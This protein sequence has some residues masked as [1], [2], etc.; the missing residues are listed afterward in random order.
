MTNMAE[1]VNDELEEILA[2]EPD[3]DL[4]D[5]ED[6]AVETDETESESESDEAEAESDDDESVVVSIDGE[7][8]SSEDEEAERAPDWVRDL[9]KQHR[10]EKRRNRELQEQLEALSGA[11]KP[12]EL[13]KKPT[14]EAADFDTDRFE[15]ELEAWYEQK[16]ER[17][18]VET[19]KK[20]KQE[21]AEKEWTGK[22]EGY[23][24]AKTG[25]KVRDYDDAEEVVQDTLS[26]T[27]QG[28]ILQ[29]A[30]N[31]ALLV[32]ALGKNPKRAKEL[33]ELTDPV[34][35]AF[36]VA[37]LE[38][39]LKVTNKKASPKP[40]KMAGSGNGRPS[41]SVDNTLERLR[42]E[43]AKTGDIS[44]VAAYKRQKRAS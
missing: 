11:G 29:G 7:T 32:Y 37:R 35:F 8:P 2:E 26:V 19:A 31:P 34:K 5:V 40:E 4:D 25:L 17:D 36:A 21:A 33:A 22:L 39:Q 27:Q 15:K 16:R 20:S 10:E 9:R 13:D 41:G 42:A 44:K 12:A 6:E 30:E 23:Q 38:T 3:V 43:A 28:M 18:E 1:E 24:A 14:L